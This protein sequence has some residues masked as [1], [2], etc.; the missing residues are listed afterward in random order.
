MSFTIKS[1]DTSPSIQYTLYE[2][3]GSTPVDLTSSTVNFHMRLK[4][5]TAAPAV[6]ASATLVDAANGV[7]R[8]DWASGDT[9]TAGEHEAEFEVT[10]Q[11]GKVE[12]F[13]NR[14]FIRVIVSEALA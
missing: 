4:G 14:G 13:P 9:A 1:G 7:V 5:S 10:F 8:Y 6:D 12:T 2:P 3:D 11:T